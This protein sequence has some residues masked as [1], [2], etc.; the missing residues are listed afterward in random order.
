MQ[1]NDNRIEP[2]MTDVDVSHVTGLSLSCLRH[3]RLL[4]RG[5]RFVKLGTAVRYRPA[6]VAA[7]LEAQ[8]VHVSVVV[9][10]EHAADGDRLAAAPA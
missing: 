6:D 4:K 5:P 8:A 3:W 7:W 10:P 9:S 1:S 2:L